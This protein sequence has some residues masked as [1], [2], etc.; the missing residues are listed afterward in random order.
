MMRKR[1][2]IKKRARWRKKCLLSVEA[3]MLISHHWSPTKTG[4]VPLYSYILQ[5]KRLVRALLT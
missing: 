3:Q 1:L 2:Y 4:L 5:I